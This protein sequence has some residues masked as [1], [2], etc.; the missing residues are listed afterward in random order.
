MS[1]TLGAVAGR[2]WR[3]SVGH[4]PTT[5]VSPGADAIVGALRQLF[6][7]A[8]R[9]ITLKPR[10]AKPDAE[11]VAAYDE[12]KSLPLSEDQLLPSMLALQHARE[13]IRCIP[14][15]FPS[16]Q[17]IIEPAGSISLEWDEGPHQFLVFATDGSG[18]I[19]FSAIFGPGEEHHGRTNFP[20]SMPRP[21]LQLLATM[22]DGQ[23]RS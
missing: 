8:A 17:P 13:L 4:T 20:G 18:T 12:V 9:S 6:G 23:Q 2:E 16:P 5:G 1:A 14:K 15:R 11:L 7:D 22:Y 21:L 19:E 3:S 10:W